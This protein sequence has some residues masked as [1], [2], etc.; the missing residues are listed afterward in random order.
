MTKRWLQIINSGWSPP[1]LNMQL[2]VIVDELHE[3]FYFTVCDQSYNTLKQS[4]YTPDYDLHIHKSIIFW[5]VHNAIGGLSMW[6]WNV[7]IGLEWTGI[8]VKI[9][10]SKFCLPAQS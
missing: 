7:S 8:E 6:T 9:N 2:Y 10:S 5:N 4:N 1:K 3:I